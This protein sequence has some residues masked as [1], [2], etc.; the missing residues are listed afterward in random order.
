MKL[1]PS[2][3]SNLWFPASRKDID[4]FQRTAEF[5]AAKGVRCMEYYHDGDGFDRVGGIL[6]QNGLDSVLIAV[7]PLKEQLLHLCATDENCRRRAIE[8]CSQMMRRAADNGAGVMM[9]CSGRI[10]LGREDQGV[11]ALAQSVEALHN[12]LIRQGHP[13]SLELEP[14]DSGV[15]ARQLIG[16]YQRTLQLCALLKQRGVPLR[17]TMDSAHTSEEGQNFFEAVQATKPFCSHVHYAN[18]TLND[19]S[20]PLYGDKHLGYEFPD[21]VWTF[22]TLHQLTTQL[23]ALYSGDEPLKIGLE[24]LCRERDPFAYFDQTWARLALPV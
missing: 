5:L 22:D 20:N 19:P 2:V 18:C 15:D 1:I 7:I 13:L 4:A 24:A 17:L 9:V 11:H 23:D 21:S 12:E 10:E 3:C 16:P 6:Q 8:L 14:C